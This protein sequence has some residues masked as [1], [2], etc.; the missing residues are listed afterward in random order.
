MLIVSYFCMST[1][2]RFLNDEEQDKN[3]SYSNKQLNKDLL[4]RYFRNFNL[5]NVI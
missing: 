3:T 2:L 5:V 4:I 1:E